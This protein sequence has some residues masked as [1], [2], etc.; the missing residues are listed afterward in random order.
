MARRKFWGWGLESETLGEAAAKR[1][2]ARVAGLTGLAPGRYRPPPELHRIRLPAVRATPPAA[3]AHLCRT[4]PYSRASHTYGKS[5]P[6]YVRAWAGD[7]AS[8]PDVV[9]WP[10]SEAEVAALLAWA[11]DAGLAVIP[12]GAGSSVVG[13][14]E[15]VVG[16]GYRGVVTVDLGRLDRVC[17]VDRRSRAAR[18]Q[19]GILGPE[20]EAQLRPSGLTLRHFP[21]SFAW[22]TLGGW[23]ATRSGGHYATLGTHIDEFVESLRV[24]A[25]AGVVETRRLPGSGAGPSPDR[26][27]I[28]SEGALGII[29]EAWMRLQDRPTHRAAASLRFASFAAAA[30][31]LCAV[32]QAG[33]HPSNLR[34]VDAAEARLAGAGDGTHHLLLLG[35]ESADHPVDAWMD[36]AL[37]CLA[38]HGGR[39]A[40]AGSPRAR[41]P[42]ADAWRG[43]FLRAPVEREALLAH[44]MLHDT[45]ESAITWDRFAGFHAAVGAAAEAAIRRVT[46]RPGH[47][48][49]RVTH[50]YPDGL[51][52]YFTLHGV[53]RPGAEIEQWREIKAAVSAALLA[54]GGTITHHHA[55]GRDHMPWYR[56]QRPPLFGDALAAAKR[57]L[58]PGGLLNPG[59]LVPA[60]SAPEAAGAAGRASGG[61]NPECGRERGGEAACG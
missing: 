4:D 42:L 15:P 32:G 11:G 53:P 21:Q 13:G 17:E 43:A 7:F 16:D 26:L 49:C 50:V 45:F 52:P 34:L 36:R 46:G 37:A 23:I 5:Y 22:S 1:I 54:A 59:V 30:E 47:V 39:P 24:V 61:G 12:Y 9:A 56:Q 40:G 10:T 60:P 33:L 51:A 55:V 19:A 31:A 44:G 28:G 35:F 3:L 29:T 2:T 18:I 25:P 48:T 14:V 38:D 41:D 8:A 27:L 6:D 20:L 58:D 57:V